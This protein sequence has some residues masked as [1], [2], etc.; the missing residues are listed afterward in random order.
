[1]T[2]DPNA[3]PDAAQWLAL[4]EDERMR[5]VCSY[6]ESVGTPSADLQVHVAVQPVVET[7]LAMG[8][9]AASRALDRLLAEGLTRHEATN[10]IGNVLESFSG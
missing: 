9:V 6:Y 4:G 5:L 2:Y 7:Y 3:A 8:V 1:M 10:A